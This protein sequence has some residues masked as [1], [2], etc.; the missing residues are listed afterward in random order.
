MGTARTVVTVVTGCLVAS[1]VAGCAS[2]GDPGGTDGERPVGGSGLPQEMIDRVIAQA[3]SETGV[4]TASIRV[5]GAEA[6]TWSDGSLGCPKPGEFYTQ[7][8]VPGYRV[9]LDV[10]AEEVNYHASE[11]GDFA[12][13]ADPQDPVEGGAAD[14]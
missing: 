5:V 12:A 1:A 2:G 8:L 14:R 7:A 11:S 10:A 3:A 13:C 9:V 6:V 4:D